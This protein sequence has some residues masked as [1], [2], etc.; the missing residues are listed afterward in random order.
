MPGQVGQGWGAAN[1]TQFLPVGPRGTQPEPQRSLP[2]APPGTILISLLFAPPD[3]ISTYQ[4]KLKDRKGPGRAAQL[5]ASWGCSSE[6]SRQMSRGGWQDMKGHFPKV[7]DS[8]FVSPAPLKR[9]PSVASGVTCSP[10]LP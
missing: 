4:Q 1:S 5:A 3:T 7:C 10:R 8:S 9:E 2:S 6:N